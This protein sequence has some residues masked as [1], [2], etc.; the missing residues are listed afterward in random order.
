MRISHKELIYTMDAFRKLSA[1]AI[2]RRYGWNGQD[3]DWL[4][5]ERDEQADKEAETIGFAPQV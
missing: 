4:D 1:V 5:A 3:G 2:C